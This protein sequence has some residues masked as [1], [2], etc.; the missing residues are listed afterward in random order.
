MSLTIVNIYDSF[1]EKQPMIKSKT[2]FLM[3]SFVF[4]ISN[5]LDAQEK[6]DTILYDDTE[7]SNQRDYELGPDDV[8]SI[9]VYDNA[10]LSG[11]FKVST[12]G[13]IV[14]PLLGQIKLAGLNA[15][16]AQKLLFNKLEKDYLYNPIV[17][18]EIKQYKSQ[19]VY[20]LGNVDKSGAYYLDRPTKLFDLLSEAN[21]LSKD[22]GKL[23]NGNNVRLI[24]Q[25]SNLENAFDIKDTSFIISLNQFL[26]EGD[27]HLNFYLQKGDIIYIP[28]TQLVHVIGEV[29]KPGSFNFEDGI[30]V[31][32]AISLA[33]GR[34]NA[35]SQKNIIVKRIVN[36]KETRMK[37][38]MSDLLKPDDIIEIPLSI[39]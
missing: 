32:K 14:Y 37:V 24:R 23:T 33:G 22:I 27:K 29:K 16:D 28:N 1:F 3:I 5:I 20:I 38:K 12:E 35:S 8:I 26:N 21:V 15:L 6:D 11:E 34:T 19:M 17:S 31:L 25:G 18:I 4:L 7:I 30:T 39:W 13:T 10:D 2:A 9:K 36:N